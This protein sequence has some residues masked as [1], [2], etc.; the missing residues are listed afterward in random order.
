MDADAIWQALSPHAKRGATVVHGHCPTGADAMAD[1][2][3]NKL[4]LTV[5]RHPADWKR[6]KRA[7]GPIRN[8][9]MVDLGADVCYAF[10]MPGSKGTINGISL[11]E[12][13]GIPVVIY[14]SDS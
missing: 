7:A 13:A 4:G 2:I 5:E 3:A 12:K 10:V 9:E 11:A 1:F 8:K 14:R 6:Y